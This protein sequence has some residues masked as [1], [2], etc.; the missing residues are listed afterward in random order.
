MTGRRGYA[1]FSVSTGAV[2]A[3]GLRFAGQAFTS[4]PVSYP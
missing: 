4:I 3:L 2:A 1:Q